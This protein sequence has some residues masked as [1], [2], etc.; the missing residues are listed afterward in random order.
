MAYRIASSEGLVGFQ[1]VAEISLTKKHRL[2][3]EVRIEDDV[4]AWSGTAVYVE[5]KVSTA[6]AAGILLTPETIIGAGATPFRVIAAATATAAGL[7]VPVY[8]NLTA[9]S[10]NAALQYGWA[11]TI[12]VA[13]TLKT[14]VKPLFSSALGLSATAGR[15][16]ITTTSSD[17][18]LGLR[19]VQSSVTTTTSLVNIY[20]NRAHTGVV[21]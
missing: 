21:L 11:L 13:P 2:G 5:Y 20:Y 8:V 7:G 14:A 3:T 17:Q 10:S 12:G 18:L 19:L 1:D 6:V 4:A 9:V 16:F 15:V